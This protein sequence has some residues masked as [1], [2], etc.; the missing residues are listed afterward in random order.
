MKQ[1]FA[2]MGLVVAVLAVS[3][4]VS[5]AQA[6]T[7]QGLWAPCAAVPDTNEYT[8]LEFQWPRSMP[9]KQTGWAWVEDDGVLSV[10]YRDPDGNERVHTTTAVVA[11]GGTLVTLDF[12]YAVP[13]GEVRFNA[14][15]APTGDI[16]L[17]LAPSAGGS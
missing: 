6:P 9:A 2:F 7:A 11:G 1:L 16:C 8:V 12:R 17:E 4:G 5:Q 13:R 10:V 14:D 3:L 15:G